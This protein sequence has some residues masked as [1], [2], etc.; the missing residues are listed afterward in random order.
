[1]RANIGE[2]VKATKIAGIAEIIGPI[3]G[4]ISKIPAKIAKDNVYGI[5]IIVSP[6]NVA[7]PIVTASII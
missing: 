3:N 6:I 4:I 1:M 5:P 7:K 2:I